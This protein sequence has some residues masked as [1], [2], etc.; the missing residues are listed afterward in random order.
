MSCRTVAIKQL[1]AFLTLG[2][3]SATANGE[4]LVIGRLSETGTI[5]NIMYYRN[6]SW[7]KPQLEWNDMKDYEIFGGEDNNNKDLVAYAKLVWGNGASDFKQWFQT[8]KP[9]QEPVRPLHSFVGGSSG[10]CSADAAVLQTNYSETGNPDAAGQTVKKRKRSRVEV[11]VATKTIG[12]KWNESEEIADVILD[13]EYAQQYKDNPRIKPLPAQLEPLV[14]QIKSKWSELEGATVQNI[15]VPKEQHAALKRELRK[16]SYH[17][18]K[19]RRTVFSTGRATLLYFESTKYFRSP[20]IRN[21]IEEDNATI[22]VSY[23]GWALIHPDGSISWPTAF[24]NLE[25]GYSANVE[26]YVSAAPYALLEINDKQYLITDFSKHFG[27]GIQVRTAIFEL[28]G[29]KFV[30]QRIY[31]GACN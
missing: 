19:V 16:T 1:L 27:N 22:G 10:D 2:I 18:L 25:P 21:P 20:L 3:L 23:R 13:P 9:Y 28:I 26:F 5:S 15:K 11:W 7:V 6:D 4:N 14:E 31:T 24:V 12:Y 30:Q 17:E 29:E 8:N